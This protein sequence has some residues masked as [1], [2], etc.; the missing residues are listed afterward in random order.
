LDKKINLNFKMEKEKSLKEFLKNFK[1]DDGK[2]LDKHIHHTLIKLLLKHPQN[3]MESFE[4]YSLRV[5]KENFNLENLEVNDN[6]QR[7]RENFSELKSYS[8]KIQKVIIGVISFHLN[9]NLSRKSK[10]LKRVK[11]RR[12][13][14]AKIKLQL[15]RS[16]TLSKISKCLSGPEST[17]AR[18]KSSCCRS[19]SLSYR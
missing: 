11:N 1:G 5:K 17:L 7:L 13:K 4:D 10:Q 6:N 14:A 8:N 12:K 18:K 3:W 19:R 16:Q 9:I 15:S 2:T